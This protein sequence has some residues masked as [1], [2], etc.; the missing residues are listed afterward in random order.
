M[1]GTNHIISNTCSAAIGINCILLAEH[2]QTIKKIDTIGVL[3]KI[4]DFLTPKQTTDMIFICLWWIGAVLLF[5]L[6]TL[7]PDCDSPN[8]MLGKIIHIPVEHRTWIHA[9]WLPLLFSILTIWF[10]IV[11]YFVIG[12]IFHLLWDN[13]SVGGVC[14]FYPV[15]KYRY[16]G[17]SGAK[18]KN[19]H[20][21]RLYRTGKV[22]EGILVGILIMLTIGFS[23]FTYMYLNNFFNVN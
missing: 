23:V 11:I 9:I 13:L 10:P 1:K 19:K 8:S 12:Y 3:D 4:V 5:Y 15:S 16:Y 18:I 20:W 2:S 17:G 6:G 22:S 7:F 14:F 21:F